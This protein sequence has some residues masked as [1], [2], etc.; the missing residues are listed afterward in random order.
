MFRV[1]A[2][3]GYDEAA[4]S[5]VQFR[6][7]SPLIRHFSAHP[8][9]TDYARLERTPWL[10]VL[11]DQ[12][13]EGFA[14]L[15][16]A[17]IVPLSTGS[18]LVGLLVVRQDKSGAIYRG[19]DRPLPEHFSRMVAI[20]EE[21]QLHQRLKKAQE[22]PAATT[23]QGPRMGQIRYFEQT[24]SGIAHDLNN[25]LTIIV[26]HAQMLEDEV[27]E[28]EIKQRTSA[29][30]QAALDG[31]DSVRRMTAITEDPVDGEFH[32]VD[33]NEIIT[34]TLDTMEPRWR[35]GTISASSVI[36]RG[37]S[38]RRI[39]EAEAEGAGRPTARL[40]VTLRPAGYI[41]GRPAELR[42]VLTNIISN[43]VD[44]LPS[45]HGRIEIIS[46]R[47]TRGAKIT[48]KDNGAG[49][50]PEV[51]RR[52]FEPRFT[53][54]GYRGS[55]LGLNISQSIIARHGGT[56]EVESTLG[57]GSTFTMLLP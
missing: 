48:V 7:G 38:R 41:S 2:S 37:I 56:L 33:V 3:R 32:M 22:S 29:I 14:R 26:S 49:M 11:P 15:G 30:R 52:V 44:A 1:R 27:E 31:A 42:R 47:D 24:A 5:T 6:L 17:L 57:G 12:E 25:I 8:V 40:V 39:A 54:K 28:G 45:E 20:I 55:G 46:D 21:A 43:A 34:S 50:S 51:M 19:T 9:P 13:R 23:Q 35:Q 53:T 10:R 18:G 16:G 4:L 36:D